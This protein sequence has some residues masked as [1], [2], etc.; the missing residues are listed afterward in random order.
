MKIIK[1]LLLSATFVGLLMCGNKTIAQTRIGDT[2]VTFDNSKNDANY[3]FMKEWQKA[4]VKNGIPSRNS[5]VVKK[6]IKPTDSDGIQEAIDSLDTGGKTSVILLK[7]GEYNIDKPITIKS[8]VVL[9]GENQEAVKLNVTIRSNGSNDKKTF[10]FK[11]SKN[12]GIEDLSM[13]YIPKKDV[14]IYDD[15]NV[16]RNKYCG[17]K[18]F[19]N[20][21]EGLKDMYV[22]FVRIDSKSKN[23]W[24]DNCVFKNSGS[25]PIE[26]MGNNNTFRGNFVDACFNKGGGGN[27]YYDIRGDYNLIAYE[28]VRRIRHF[29]IQLGA[30]YNVVINCDLEV[31]V[32][33]HNDDDGFNLVEKNKIK[34]E[35]WRSWGAFAS[36]GSRFGHR[37]PGENNIIFNNDVSG[38]NNSSQFGGSDK[39]FV[40]DQ[41]SKPRVLRNSAPTGGTFYPAILNGGGSNISVSSV[42]LSHAAIS[43]NVDETRK[44][45]ETVLPNNAT[46]KSVTWSSSDTSIATVN[47]S[48]SVTAVSSG[49]AIITVTSNDGNKTA[50]ST[51]T[52][53]DGTGSQFITLTPIHDAY[54]QGSDE[55]RFNNEIIRV[56]NGKRVGY[57]QFDLRSIS[58]SITNAKLKLTCINDSGS[59]EVNVELGNNNDWTES[60]LSNKNKPLSST[61]L[62]SLD[63][64]YSLG[65]TYT[66]DLDNNKIPTNG[67]VSIIV[68]HVEGNDMAFASKENSTN[69]PQLEISYLPT[70]SA[71]T[72]LK[73]DISKNDNNV[74]AYPNPFNNELSVLLGNNDI[75]SIKVTNI[76]GRII[77]EK[78]QISPNENKI[79][80]LLKN[81]EN[82]MYIIIL[83]GKEYTK[84]L[85]VIKKN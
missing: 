19:G 83:E 6:E 16:N 46:N 29:T 41:Y 26:I 13:E 39:V 73:K 14:T 75:H 65:T 62:G 35:Q 24:V 57:F 3:P 85:K 11:E 78:Q 79:D 20:N 32:N 1:S 76:E 40:F 22:T 34:S 70:S 69:V 63:S 44:L 33:F 8:N 56:E 31:D 43:L 71:R 23:C 28:R 72:T 54:L 81:R 10:I 74:L 25:D 51:I 45:N 49:V 50:S 17:D 67:I 4:G 15:K 7:E 55:T 27:G 82:G 18:C 53:V 9:R 59:G 21:P 12:S 58:G 68:S 47:S 80:L 84:T 37:K 30:K 2:G 64:D 36:G 38:K 61:L 77:Y 60:N 42:S 66:W 52:V 48:G 5:L